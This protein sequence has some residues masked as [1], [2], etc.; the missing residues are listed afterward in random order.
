M[1]ETR[2]SER[3]RRARESWRGETEQKTCG[4]TVQAI[5]VAYCDSLAIVIVSFFLFIYFVAFSSLLP[6]TLSQHLAKMLYV[7][8]LGLSD[9]R[10]ITVKGLDA[11]R[12]CE[13]IYLEAYTSILMVDKETLVCLPVPTSFAASFSAIITTMPHSHNHSLEYPI[14][15]TL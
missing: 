6:T 13:R 3:E 14:I 4:S 9:E 7:I 1:A 10:D 5:T 15:Y 2:E 12:S 8:G 11:V